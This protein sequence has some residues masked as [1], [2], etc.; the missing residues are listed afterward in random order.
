MKQRAPAT[1]R[2]REPIARVLRDVLPEQGMVL[3]VASGS[4]EHALNSIY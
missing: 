3:E 2:N 4:G 1:E